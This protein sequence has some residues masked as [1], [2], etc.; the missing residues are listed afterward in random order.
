MA[1]N[2]EKSFIAKMTIIAMGIGMILVTLW[3]IA[4]CLFYKQYDAGYNIASSVAVK[5]LMGMGGAF[6]SSW[7]FNWFGLSLPIF[8]IAP[9]IWGY[10][11]IRYKSFIKLYG[12]F[13]ALILGA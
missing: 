2:K 10:E 13:F 5:N 4:S 1:K 3:L 6:V 7:I 11:V 8:L 12:R 9:L